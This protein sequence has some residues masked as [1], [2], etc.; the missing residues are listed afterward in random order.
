MSIA[1]ATTGGRVELADVTG[2]AIGVE[3]ATRVGAVVCEEAP[4]AEA[5]MSVAGRTVAAVVGAVSGGEG[6]AIGG[7]TGT[8]ITLDDTVDAVVGDP[9][10]GDEAGITASAVVC[11]GADATAEGGEGGVDS[12]I[13][14]GVGGGCGAGDVLVM[15]QEME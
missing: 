7:R 12:G 13:A 6:D 4:A 14:E 8:T 1:G 3:L 5:G 2:V 15:A 11:G 10:V 9:T